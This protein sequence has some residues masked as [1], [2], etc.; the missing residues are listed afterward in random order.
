MADVGIIVRTRDRPLTLRRALDSIVRQSFSD[1]HVAIVNDGGDRAALEDVLDRHPHPFADRITVVHH[2]TSK[3]RWAAANAGVEALDT[4]YLTIHDDD[5]SWH[6]TFLARTT[7]ELDRSDDLIGGVM[8]RTVE[9]FEKIV[10]GEPVLKR[11]RIFKPDLTS[12]TIASMAQ[13]NQIVPISFVYRRTIH[14]E[15]GM[16]DASLPVLGDWEFYLRLLRHYDIRLIDEA[17]AYWHKRLDQ[18]SSQY[19]NSVIGRVSQHHETEARIRN[20][21]LRE[22]MDAGIIG[23]GTLVTLGRQ[24][25]RVDDVVLAVLQRF[26]RAARVRSWLG[27]V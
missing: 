17:L 13:A 20:R 3:G 16:Y 1:W 9:R 10:G 7:A 11:E 6:P 27:K 2:D 26:R 25:R 24:S 4:N 21:L 14:G 8:T 5:D 18:A 19:G 23:M 15:V 22:D 12:I